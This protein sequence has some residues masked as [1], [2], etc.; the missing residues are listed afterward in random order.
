MQTLISSDKKCVYV[1]FVVNGNW[2][3]WSQVVVS[4]W[5]Q[6]ITVR[7]LTTSSPVKSGGGRID[8]LDLPLYFQ[9]PVIT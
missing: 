3:A 6:D 4:G 9:T 2:T 5:N 1:R 7:S 8:V